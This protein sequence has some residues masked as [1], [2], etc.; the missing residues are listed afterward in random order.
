M[1]DAGRCEMRVVTH[2]HAVGKPWRRSG[3]TPQ[4]FAQMPGSEQ[5]R[6][7]RFVRETGMRGE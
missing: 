2:P 6:F 5:A 3:G 1:L 7:A 4:A